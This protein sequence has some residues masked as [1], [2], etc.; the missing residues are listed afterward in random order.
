MRR[1][2]TEEE[3][4]FLNDEL[5]RILPSIVPESMRYRT[6]EGILE[7]LRSVELSETEVAH[8]I[9]ELDDM[10]LELGSKKQELRNSLSKKLGALE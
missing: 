7:S 5:K 2:I 4:K 10:R 6:I 3:R 9:R 1:S 8:L